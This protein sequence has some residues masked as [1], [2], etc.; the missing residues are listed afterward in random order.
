MN[1]ISKIIQ[2]FCVDYLVEKQKPFKYSAAIRQFTDA[3]PEHFYR[4]FNLDES[5]YLVKCSVG[6]GNWSEVPW[7]A[8]FDLDITKSARNGYYVVLLF[9][10]DMQRMHLALGIGWTQFLEEFGVKA[11]RE[12]IMQ[13]RDFFVDKVDFDKSF[14]VGDSR[15]DGENQLSDG[16]KSGTIISRSYD[17]GTFSP[18][19]L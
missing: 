14:Q 6:N 3:L 1:E 17:T 15:L 12:K 19:D 8:L 11:G 18:E 5:K 7:L 16:Y 2:K 13:Y 4:E 9:D 10:N